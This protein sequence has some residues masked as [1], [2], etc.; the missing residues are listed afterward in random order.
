MRY[1]IKLIYRALFKAPPRQPAHRYTT[2]Q[3]INY[4]TTYKKP[5]QHINHGPT[6]KKPALND[7][8]AKELIPAFPEAK[9]IH[10]IDGDTV[11]IDT[12]R[13][14]IKLRLDSIDCPEV[15]QQWGDTA[16]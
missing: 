14:R 15:G 3:P 8:A 1:L 2:A 11:V 7:L 13:S 12:A 16:K 6:Y 10:V 5:A 4:R 9:A